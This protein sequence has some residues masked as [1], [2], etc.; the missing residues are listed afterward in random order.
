MKYRYKILLITSN[1]DFILKDSPVFDIKIYSIMLS[2]KRINIYINLLSWKLLII[3]FQ[4]IQFALCVPV[5][6]IIWSI[7]LE[8]MKSPLLLS[9][10]SIKNSHKTKQ[11]EILICY[12]DE[13]VYLLR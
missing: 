8:F 12:P 10:L 5:Y 4:S 11:E 2:P 1:S 13:A 3:F 6:F 9:D 7:H